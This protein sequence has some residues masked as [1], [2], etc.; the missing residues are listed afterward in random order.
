MS[1]MNVNRRKVPDGIGRSSRCSGPISCDNSNLR[2]VGGR[3]AGS[4][5]ACVMSR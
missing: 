4:S 3:L 2:R 1:W 5:S